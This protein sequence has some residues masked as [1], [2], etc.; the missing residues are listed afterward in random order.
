M[1]GGHYRPGRL[2]FQ[3]VAAELDHVGL[4]VQLVLE[5][6]MLARHAAVQAEAH[7]AQLAG[8]SVARDV[9]VAVLRTVILY[10]DR[11]NTVCDWLTQKEIQII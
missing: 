10:L 7:A 1:S 8:V 11:K 5:Q 9:S 4:Q 3:Q 6:E 2:L